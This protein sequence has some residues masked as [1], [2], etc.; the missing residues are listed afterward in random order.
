[1]TAIDGKSHIL[2]LLF[3][4]DVMVGRGI[5]QILPHPGDPKLYE[6]YM[7]SAEEYVELAE[8]THGP[9]RQPVDFTYIWGDARPDIDRRAIDFRIVNL[10]TPVTTSQNPAHKEINYK[11]HPRNAEALRAFGIDC[12]SIANNH[13]LD[14]GSKG[15]IE[16]IDSLKRIGIATAGAGRDTAEADA[17]AILRG[18]DG[19]RILV[20]GAAMPPSGVPREWA[21]GENK[22]GVSLL[23]DLSDA[24]VD[25]VASRVAAAKGPRDIIVLSLHWGGNWGYGIS[26]KEVAFAH[27]LVD[28]AGVDILHGHSS[29]HARAIEAYRGKLILYGCGDFMNDYE[30]IRGYE[31]FRGDLALAYVA[32]INATEDACLTEFSVVPYRIRKF[33][34]ERASNEEIDWLRGIL[35]RES[36]RFG[37]QLMVSRDRDLK[38]VWHP[39]LSGRID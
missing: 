20:F 22:A 5:D 36:S 7:T 14:W 2:K 8:T 6:S 23:G 24:S 29:H 31:E 16:T 39:A 28:R 15:L 17:P 25:A 11:M 10:E 26:D 38:L 34:L 21:A 13:V 1:M 4:G 33:R 37:A 9:I 35:T 3:T 12:C 32:S 18:T 19:V 30:G 27:A